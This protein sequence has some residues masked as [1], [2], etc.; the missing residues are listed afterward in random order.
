M[1]V[2]TVHQPPLGKGENAPDPTRF[3]FV[4]DGFYVWGFLL[5]VLWMLRHRLWLVAVL[6]VA[7]TL[8]LD[9][10]LGY[11]GV[12]SGWRTLVFLAIA[13]L[14]GIEGATLRRWTL[15]RRGWTNVGVVVA[16]DPDD[17]ERR[18][19]V[20]WQA[21]KRPNAAQPP[22]QS[23]SVVRGPVAPQT[24]ARHEPADVI[25]SF[26]QPERRT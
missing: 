8:L 18:F 23:E 4:R 19:F 26:P 22:V 11:A 6:F 9:V 13:F 2:Y 14:V 15:N 5:S 21:G 17:A 24:Y 1:A 7:G 25:G 10:G 12:S 20:N 3:T 16:D